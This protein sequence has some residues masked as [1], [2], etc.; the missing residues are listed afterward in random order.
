MRLREWVGTV[1]LVVVAIGCGGRLA[2]LPGEGGDDA[3]VDGDDGALP[4]G[5]PVDER[6]PT[7]VPVCSGQLSKCLAPDAGIVQTGASVIQC[8]PEEYVGP[9]TLVLQR[10]SGAN[11]QTLQTKVVEEPGFGATFY[12]STGPPTLLTYRVC[13]LANSTTALCGTAFITQG[14]PNCRCEPTTCSLNTACN[15]EIDDQCGG[16]DVCGACENGMPCNAY[17][18]CCKGN[19]MSDG[20]GGCVCAPGE[21]VINGVHKTCPSWAWN[22]VSCSCEFGM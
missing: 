9:W 22:T 18:T 14:P 7:P 6:G 19:F 12:D 5:A 21:V 1:P 8:Q 20:W 17:H 2:P 11:W 15:T 13:A 3:S 4:D 16:V 10:L